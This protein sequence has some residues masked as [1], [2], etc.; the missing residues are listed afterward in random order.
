MIGFIS[1]LGYWKKITLKKRACFWLDMKHPID[2]PIHPER[3]LEDH[4]EVN[5]LEFFRLLLRKKKNL[6]PKIKN[7]DNTKNQMAWS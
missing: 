4:P 3:D 2:F 1:P 5:H 7:E 6:S